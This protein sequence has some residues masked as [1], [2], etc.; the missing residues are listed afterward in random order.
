[1]MM[2]EI[3]LRTSPN[4]TGKTIELHVT[5]VVSLGEEADGKFMSLVVGALIIRVIF[6]TAADRR[7]CGIG[8]S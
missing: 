4:D 3:A 1:M 5:S 6:V 2:K 7:F 8:S